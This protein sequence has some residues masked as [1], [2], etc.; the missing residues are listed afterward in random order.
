MNRRS[1]PLGLLLA[2]TSLSPAPGRDR[3]VGTSYRVPYRLTDT[4]HVLVRVRINGRGPFNFLVDTGAPA[5]YVTT[6]AA[7]KAALG[8]APDGFWTPV[9][10]LDIEG[11]A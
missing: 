5:L 6:E 2:L 4:N 9:D 1:R 10:R 7:R 11:G 3:E 8:P